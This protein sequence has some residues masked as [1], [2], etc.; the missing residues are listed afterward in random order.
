MLHVMAME[1][2]QGRDHL[3]P[4]QQHRRAIQMRRRQRVCTVH[5]V[6]MPKAIRVSQRVGAMF[7]KMLRGTLRRS[8]GVL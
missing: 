6:R 3:T 4:E 1:L 2:M 7:Q 5:T 8:D